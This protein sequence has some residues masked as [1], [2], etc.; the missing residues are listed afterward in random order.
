MGGGFSHYL[1]SCNL[2]L[3]WRQE[4]SYERQAGVLG[5]PV[6]TSLHIEIK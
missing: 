2:G 3:M 4:M 5:V 6:A 1:S